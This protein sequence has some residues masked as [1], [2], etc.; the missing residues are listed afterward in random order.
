M[1][2]LLISC[3]ALG[4]MTAC[5]NKNSGSDQTDSTS[6]VAADTMGI[7]LSAKEK[8]AGVMMVFDGKSFKGWHAFKKDSITGWTIANGVLDTK[9]GNGD[10]VSDAEFENFD[11]TFDFKVTKAGNS[12]V[13]YM[14]QNDPKE[15]ETWHT[16]IEF[17]IID[18][19]GWPDPLHD[20]Q[21]SG[22]VYDLYPPLKMAAKPAE[23]WNTAEIRVTKEKVTHTI[24]GKKTAE[25]VWNSDDF[26][27]KVAVSKFKD[28]P[29]AKK[30]KGHIVL[31]DH[32]QGVAFRNVKIKQL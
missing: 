31:Q 18:D 12:G 14:V 16:G 9:G 26:K 24:N 30:Q 27:K 25:Y 4:L 13:M 10:L 1:K 5:A 17:Q 32:G 20:V 29:F 23:E 11:L 2:K 6:V 21:H 8:A 19:N 15:E 3:I 7:G 28:M 22:A